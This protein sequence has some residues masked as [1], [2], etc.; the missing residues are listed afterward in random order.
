MQGITPVGPPGRV[1]QYDGVTCRRPWRAAGIVAFTIVAGPRGRGRGAVHEDR[2]CRRRRADL[3][4]WEEGIDPWLLTPPGDPIGVDDLDLYADQFDERLAGLLT[5]GKTEASL[6]S[7]PVSHHR[8]PHVVV[9]V[10]NYAEYRVDMK[11]THAVIPAAFVLATAEL[12]QDAAY[13]LL[14]MRGWMG[15]AGVVSVCLPDGRVGGLHRVRQGDSYVSTAYHRPAMRSA[16]ALICVPLFLAGC[17]ES[18]QSSPSAA[19]PDAAPR[20]ATALVADYD[21]ARVSGLSPKQ[22]QA[23]Y[24]DFRKALAELP[25]LLPHDPWAA[26]P[27]LGIPGPNYDRWDMRRDRDS[28][29][30]PAGG[31]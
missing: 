29:G 13:G 9:A 3:T 31:W 19:S 18:I 5:E 26:P 6:F 21:T 1:A 30:R 10:R 7:V 27:G 8:T 15:A 28:R 11:T 20:S 23:L 2:L 12:A 22:W 14:A 25:P 16:K 4:R 17:G 24:A